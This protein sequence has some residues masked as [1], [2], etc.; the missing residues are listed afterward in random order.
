M[1]YNCEGSQASR[2]CSTAITRTC[3]GY[4]SRGSSRL[5]IM[6][7]EHLLLHAIFVDEMI[8]SYVI[9]GRPRISLPVNAIVTT[10]L[11]VRDTTCSN[12]SEITFRSQK[13]L[14][15]DCGHHSDSSSITFLRMMNLSARELSSLHDGHIYLSFLCI[16]FPLCSRS[17]SSDR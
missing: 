15:L 7:G 1:T 8:S 3:N 14:E 17:P 4:R 11:F 2:S 10:I 13:R 5:G 6:R 16:E 9:F 12:V